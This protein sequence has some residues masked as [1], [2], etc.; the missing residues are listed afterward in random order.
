MHKRKEQKSAKEHAS[1]GAAPS[2]CS[3][4]ARPASTGV[5]DTPSFPSAPVATPAESPADS[6]SIARLWRCASSRACAANDA[7]SADASPRKLNSRLRPLASSEGADAVN[8]SMSA[9]CNASVSSCRV[10]VLRLARANVRQRCLYA[11]STHLTNHVNRFAEVLSKRLTCCF[12]CSKS[13][14]FCSAYSATCSECT[15]SRCTW[16]CDNDSAFSRASC[17]S[18]ATCDLCKRSVTSLVYSPDA[19][20]CGHNATQMNVQQM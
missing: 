19:C 10:P 4:L 7:A 2:A 3:L 16:S 13:L 15:A 12:S 17:S 11:P 1:I 5:P 20:L 9:A 14:A 6:A 18:A 8:A